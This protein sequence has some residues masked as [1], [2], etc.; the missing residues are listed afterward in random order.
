MPR[1]ND[2]DPAVPALLVVALVTF[3]LAIAATGIDHSE[4]L[5]DLALTTVVDSKYR[6][7]GPAL[8]IIEVDGKRVVCS[9][10]HHFQVGD[11]VRYDPEDP[12]HCRLEA[13]LGE[14][15]QFQ[16]VRRGLG[17]ALAVGGPTWVVM[18]HLKRKKRR[19]RRP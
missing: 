13:H 10:T 9:D 17:L 5:R 3:G 6:A 1:S 8:P 11:P 14:A 2:E 12:A 16:W 7:K 4:R 18:G 15:T 19:T